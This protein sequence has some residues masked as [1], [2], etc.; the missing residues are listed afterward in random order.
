VIAE[1]LGIPPADHAR[2]VRWN[3]VILRMSYLVVGSP[4]SAAVMAAFQS[5]TA[6]MDDYL[7]ALLVQR[8]AEARDDLLTRLAQAEIDGER[9]AQ[10]DILGFF[11]LLL[12]AGSETT[13]NL[14]TNAIVCF[15]EHPDQLARLRGSHMDLLPSAIE[16][17]LR[18]RA[19]LQWMFRLTTR[20]VELHG[21]TLPA[22]TLLLAVIGSANRDPRAFA[23]PE[24]FD[25]ARERNPHLAFGHGNHFCLGAPL[26]RLE[27]RVA[28][29]ELLTR[30]G[31]FR[32]A[33]EQPWEPRKGLHVHGPT[34]L[35]I[36]FTTMTR[37]AR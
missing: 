16:E 33:G 20:E 1:M 22:G 34:R 30:I 6:E 10:R 21:Q 9:L 31:D 12:L 29:G 19:P 13:T 8:R 4:D 35:S 7:A 25:I 15:A 28:L 11:Q 32:L 2:F 37:G 17:V 5:I 24:R 36:R 27:G 23:D 14:I 3:D 18:Y 26:A